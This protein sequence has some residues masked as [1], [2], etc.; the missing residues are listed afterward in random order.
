MGNMVK[1]EEKPLAI[2]LTVFLR[3]DMLEGTK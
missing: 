3:S 2:I 1:G